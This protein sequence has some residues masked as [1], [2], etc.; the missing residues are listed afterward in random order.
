MCGVAGAFRFDGPPDRA[1]VPAM[2]RAMVHRGPDDEHL[3]D[4]PDGT[5]G[6]R[7][8]S[9]VDLEGGRQPLFDG[10]RRLALAMNGEVY[11]HDALRR[12]FD[13]N[14]ARFETASDTEVAACAIATSG[15]ERGLSLLDGQFAIAAYDLARRRLWLARDRIGQKPLYWTRLPDGTLLFA[16]E[17]KGL[18]AHPRVRRAVDPRAVEQLLLF[19]YVPAPRTIYQ[20]I[21]K[22]E[23]GCL[24][25][26]D[27]DG[28]RVSRWWTP[29]L[30]GADRATIAAERF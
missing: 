9:I 5:M 27:A 12:M 3:L 11:N 4:L 1:A 10:D 8:L 6:T 22:L 30:V 13:A 7:R 24:L 25:T 19:E 21:F 15:V 20:G 29:P 23:P 16:S 18:L 2:V 14:G 28:H 17:L 26:A